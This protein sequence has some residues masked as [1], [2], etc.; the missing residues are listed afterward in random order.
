MGYVYGNGT[1]NNDHKKEA[2]FRGPPGFLRRFF[3]ISISVQW[4]RISRH[5]L[6]MC[7]FQ[8]P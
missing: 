5:F 1:T 7:G 2:L 4:W 3:H 8:S 6:G